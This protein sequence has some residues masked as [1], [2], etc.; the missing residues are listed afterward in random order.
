VKTAGQLVVKVDMPIM[1]LRSGDVV[2][3]YGI[4]PGSPERVKTV[5]ILPAAGT[6]WRIAQ[7]KLG[8]SGFAA[9][10][11]GEYKLIGMEAKNNG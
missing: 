5:L 7:E 1:G 2:A 3:H 4:D 6:T 10:H 9:L 8:L 11:P